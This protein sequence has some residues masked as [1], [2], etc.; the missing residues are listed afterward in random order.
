MTDAWAVRAAGLGKRYQVT[1][2]RDAL[3]RGLLPHVFRPRHVEPFW[4]LQQVDL[5]VPAGEC[6]TIVGSNGAG[7]STLLALLAGVTAPTTGSVQVRGRITALLGLGGGFHPELSGEE[8]VWLSGALLGMS[9]RQLREALQ[10]IAAFADL[11]GFLDAPLSTYSTGMQMR[12]GF[13]IAIHADADVLLMDEVMAVGDPAF[14]AKCLARLHALKAQGK[15]L[16]IVTHHHESLASITDRVVELERG[17]VISDG[18]MCT[19]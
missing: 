17:K 3:V 10:D 16:M 12:L 11:D 9:R 2:E 1:H 7:K 19:V 4:A 6:V 8:N 15:T 18:V 5:D 13:A 14:Q